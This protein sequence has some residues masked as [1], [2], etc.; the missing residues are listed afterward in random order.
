MAWGRAGCYNGGVIEMNF[1][2]AEDINWMQMA[3][4]EAEKA[5]E[6]GE[7][8][9]GAVAVLEG[10]II[11]RGFNRKESDQYPTAHA[12]LIALKKAAKTKKK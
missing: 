6:L 7:V 9:V 1:F 4:A 12:E 3:L 8:P 10:Q 11:G 5:A 2:K